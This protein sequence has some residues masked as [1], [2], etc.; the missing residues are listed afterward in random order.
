ML[1]W[2]QRLRRTRP[3]D[4]SG[5]GVYKTPVLRVYPSTGQDKCVGCGLCAEVC[6]VDAIQIGATFNKDKTVDVQSFDL[7]MGACVQCGLC[8]DAC[9]TQAIDFLPSKKQTQSLVYTKEDLLR[10]GEDG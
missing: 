2:L 8:V 5:G 1:S 3:H 9:P 10:G 6:P 4:V 7:D